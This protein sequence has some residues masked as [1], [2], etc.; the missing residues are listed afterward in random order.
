MNTLAPLESL[1]DLAIEHGDILPL[2]DELQTF[3]GQLHIPP[4]PGRPYVISNFVSTLDGVV[5]LDTPGHKGG[6]DIS[7]LSKP[8]HAVMGILRTLA[9][10]VIVGAGTFNSAPGHL[11]TAEHI[12]PPFAAA[13][14]KFRGA[15]GKAGPPLNVVVSAQGNVDL[16]QPVLQSGRVPALIITTEQGAQRLHGQPLSPS[17]EITTIE[18]SGHISTRAILEAV[19]RARSS[20]IILTEGGPRLL[21]HFLAERCLDEQFLTLSPQVAGREDANER[22]GLVMGASFAPHNPRWARL[23]SV[24]RAESHL[25]LR[26]SFASMTT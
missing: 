4:H 5:E 10:A 23:L 7:G 6:G 2:P 8:D 16:R 22:P 9:D 24:K 14:K 26:Y 12:Y 11:W 13:Y 21:S 25:F 19:K 18:S 20:E 3:Y 15:L 1:F 17:V